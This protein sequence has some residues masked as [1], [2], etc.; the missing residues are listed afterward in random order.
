MHKQC[1]NSGIFFPHPVEHHHRY[2]GEVPR[3][4]S[5]GRGDHHRD[6][7]DHEHHQSGKDAQISGKTEAEERHV[8]LQEI[9]YPDACGVE[10]EQS[11][12]ADV[13]QGEHALPYIAQDAPH[14]GKDGHI[15]YQKHGQRQHG[16]HAHHDDVE[17]ARSQH[18][19]QPA[20]VCPRLAEERTEH[21]GLQEQGDARNQPHAKGVD[22]SF[23]HYR[24][25][26][27]GE[28]GAV[29]LSQYAATGNLAHAGH[30]EVG[31]I[32]HKDS[33]HAIPRARM[34]V[35][36][37]QRQFPSPSSEQVAQHAEHQ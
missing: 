6:A 15:P 20:G 2:D 22:E 30:Y 16:Q 28:G 29:I 31:R 13:A 14:A 26:R 18:F 5:I 32:G 19:R 35:E 9:A 12:A 24:P 25:Q 23:G 4:G 36:R 10:E 17:M 8:E 7:P 37:C 34:F 33:V 21:A 3:P 11:F 1:K 27:F